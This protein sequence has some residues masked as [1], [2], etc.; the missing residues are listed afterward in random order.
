MWYLSFSVCFNIVI[1]LIPY[2]KAI[3]GLNFH[4]CNSVS[5]N[6]LCLALEGLEIEFGRLANMLPELLSSGIIF[7]KRELVRGG[8]RNNTKILMEYVRKSQT[9]RST[10]DHLRGKIHFVYCQKTVW[11]GQICFLLFYLQIALIKTG[12]DGRWGDEKE[13]HRILVWLVL[14]FLSILW[15]CS[16]T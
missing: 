14:G 5:L 1:I 6:V 4:T 10:K 15:Q 3:K 9:K 13:R 11:I 8:K 12:K 2:F 16:I 7:T